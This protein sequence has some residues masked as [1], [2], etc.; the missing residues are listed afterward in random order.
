MASLS[1]SSQHLWGRSNCGWV[2][3][4]TFPSQGLHAAVFLMLF[5]FFWKIFSWY[6]YS[7]VC[8][9]HGHETQEYWGLTGV[10]AAHQES[11][12]LSVHSLFRLLHLNLRKNNSLACCGWEE[13]SHELLLRLPYLNELWTKQTKGM[14]SWPTRIINSTFADICLVHNWRNQKGVI[15]IILVGKIVYLLKLDTYECF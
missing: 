9:T 13:V 11:D 3:L 6:F 14:Q 7:L 12:L 2:G 1:P 4:T 5:R 10:L 15:S 8:R